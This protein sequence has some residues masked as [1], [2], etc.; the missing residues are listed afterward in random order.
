[1]TR[2]VIRGGGRCR[3]A[4]VALAATLALGMSACGSEAQS[5]ADAENPLEGELITV[6]VGFSPGGGFDTYARTF[7][8]YLAEELGADVTV[9]NVPGA[10]GLLALKQ[11]M[12]AEPDGTTLY[13]MDGN[14]I[15]GSVV[16]GAEGADFSL[17]DL[18][19]I[20]RVADY[21]EVVAAGTDTGYTSFNDVL[22]NSSEFRWGGDGPGG[23]MYV[24]PNVLMG[25]FGKRPNITPGY[26]G[27]SSVQAALAAG[28][29]DGSFVAE[30]QQQ[31]F[32]ES[33]DA[34]PLLIMG[35]ERSKMFPDVPTIL[36]MNLNGEQE[37]VARAYFSLVDLGRV[38][39]TSAGTP[40]AELEALRDGVAAMLKNPKLIRD[41]K[42]K[43]LPIGY[44]GPDGLSETVDKIQNVPEPFVEILKRGY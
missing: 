7:A 11:V 24:G 18:A 5:A 21:T 37:S 40:D 44:M 23:S 12:A 34:K 33:G 3:Y 38:L 6:V 26:D 35:A 27:S 10:G 1:M 28:E 43:A 29:V 30:E 32:V 25:I 41:F 36:E 14:G 2:H 13:L 17:E 39:V 16:A 31:P 9:E 20:G 42:K 15:S 19:Y 22:E 8:P 4:A